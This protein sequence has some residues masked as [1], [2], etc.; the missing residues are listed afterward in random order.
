MTSTKYTYIYM[1]VCALAYVLHMWVVLNMCYWYHTNM[2][3]LSVRC[4]F[5]WDPYSRHPLRLP[6]NAEWSKLLRGVV[7]T[8][9]ILGASAKQ[10]WKA[11]TS[12]VVYLSVISF[13]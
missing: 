11:S 8:K 9:Y 5:I 13:L 7:I 3:A 6:E 1:Y 4:H 12:L 2:A 10:F